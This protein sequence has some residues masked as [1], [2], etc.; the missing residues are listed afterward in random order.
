[1]EALRLA[2]L[3]QGRDCSHLLAHP[4]LKLHITHNRTGKRQV[5]YCI[6]SKLRAYT[7]AMAKAMCVIE[8]Y[9]SDQ[10]LVQALAQDVLGQ[11]N[12]NEHHLALALFVS[13]PLRAQIAAHQL[14]HALENHLAAGALHIQNTLVAQHLR[15]IDIDDSAQ[16]VL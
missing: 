4:H 8:H 11:I 15:A 1:M 9:R 13:A 3:F 14:V 16:K 12:A 6:S 10:A 2:G 7:K 5:C